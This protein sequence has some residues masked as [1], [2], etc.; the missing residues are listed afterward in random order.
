[1]ATIEIEGK[2]IGY[3]VRGKGPAAM[4][5]NHSGTSSLSWSERFLEA[6]A[7]TLTVI[8][9]DYRG[10]GHSS[11][12]STP[13]SLRD[14]AADGRAVLQKEGIARTAVIG[15][16]MGGAV[17][18]E[19]VL[20]FPAQV[21]M[22]VLLGTFAGQR[23]RVAPAPEVLEIVEEVLPRW[24]ELG[25]IERWRRLLP[26]LYGPSFLREHENLA[27]ELELK[28]SRFTTSGTI[29]R[30][31]EAVGAF[32][33]HDRLPAISVPTLVVHGAEDPIIPAKNGAV[34]AGRIPDAAYIELE[35]VGHLPAVERPL[36]VADHVLHLARQAAPDGPLVRPDALVRLH[37]RLPGSVTPEG[38][39]KVRPRPA[40]RRAA[41]GKS[42][43]PSRP[44]VV[45]VAPAAGWGRTRTGGR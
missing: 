28:G 39:S 32:E 24:D 15:T 4:L 5:F 23:H 25:S 8:T 43:S 7:E 30:H 21:T 2:L 40:P 12:G 27:L 20:A 45:K 33:S 26:T 14:L 44:A 31:G 10:T 19:F 13:F 34:L 6:L 17:A 36:E 29:A 22:L 41:P 38:G 16:S 3:D 37:P 9:I 18:Q 35:G 11:L 1:M 42:P